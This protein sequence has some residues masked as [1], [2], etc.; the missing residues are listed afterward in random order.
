M[1][2]FLTELP[3]LD[4]TLRAPLSAPTALRFTLSGVTFP[5]DS[6]FLVMTISDTYRPTF[7][8]GDGCHS[9]MVAGGWVSIVDH[10]W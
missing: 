2:S 1:T 7:I 10:S 4:L 8:Y 6:L 9:G 3:V 5:P